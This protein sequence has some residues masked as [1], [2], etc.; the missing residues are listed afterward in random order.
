MDRFDFYFLQLV[1]EGEIDGAFDRSE[2]AQQAIMA[3]AGLV[4]ILQGSAVVEHNPTPDLTVDVPIST[5]YDSSGQ[6]IRIPSLQVVDMSVDHLAQSTGVLGGGNTNILALFVFFERSLS[7]PRIDGNSNSIDF[8][9]DESFDFKVVQSGESASPSP[10][11]LEGDK[12]LLADITLAF[13]TTQ[14]FNAGISQSRRQDAFVLS[15]GALTV[16]EGTPEESDQAT[17]THL[18]N[19]ITGVASLHPATAIDYAGGAAW[20]D[21]ATNPAVTVE[22]QLDKL[23]TDLNDATGQGGADK[24]GSGALT[25]WSGG[26]AR[27]AGSIWDQ[28]NAVGLDLGANGASDD[29][30]E[31]IG[32]EAHTAAGEGSVDLSVGNVRSQLNELSD[33]AVGLTGNQTIAG[34]KTFSGTTDIAA[35]GTLLSLR[36]SGTISANVNNWN[37]SSFDTAT[38]IGVINTT[39]SFN[40][41]GIDSTGRDGK[42]LVILNTNG[43]NTITLVDASASSLV[44]NRFSLPGGAN[45]VIPALGSAI[46]YYD[47]SSNIWR[48][49]GSA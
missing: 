32:A 7:D 41:T 39:G 6:R 36:G 38:F 31:R 30:A 3:D 40:V 8:Q 26:R 47:N 22:V 37:E 34:D 11:A 2:L 13:G 5:G 43:S 29:G 20:H 19:H 23:I 25:A 12:I 1:S 15:A 48:L 45:H 33:G 27:A 4:G 9:R 14:I 49:L 46:L 35:L 42:L 16:N 24:L 28:L 10:P 18:N 44:A 17:L 21:G